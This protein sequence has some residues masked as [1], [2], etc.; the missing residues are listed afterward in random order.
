M[1]CCCTIFMVFMDFGI[2][3]VLVG[4]VGAMKYAYYCCNV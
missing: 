1:Y 3:G 2:M 4:F